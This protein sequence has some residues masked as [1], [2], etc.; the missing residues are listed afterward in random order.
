[1]STLHLSVYRGHRVATLNGNMRC[2]EIKTS[3][4]LGQGQ[5]IWST[6]AGQMG[7]MK[8]AFNLN[9]GHLNANTAKQGTYG[10]F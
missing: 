5:R 4:A 1:M 2:S 6:Q 8:L 3:A 10:Y 9:N 7:P